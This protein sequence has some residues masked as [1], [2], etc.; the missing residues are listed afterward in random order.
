MKDKTPTLTAETVEQLIKMI[1]DDNRADGMYGGLAQ[2]TN[3]YDTA[4][5]R[6]KKLL[7]ALTKKDL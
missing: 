6:V 7:E 2:F 4:I 5:W 3:G 1:D